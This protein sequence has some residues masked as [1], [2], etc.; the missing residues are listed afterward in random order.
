[1]AE[2]HTRG[3]Y[4][5]CPGPGGTCSETS[6]GVESCPDCFYCAC[7]RDAGYTGGGKDTACTAAKQLSECEVAPVRD[8]CKYDEDEA[9]DS[10]WPDAA[11]TPAVKYKK[12]G[13]PAGSFMKMDCKCKD[14]WT[15]IGAQAGCQ[16]PDNDASGPWCFVEGDCPGARDPNGSPWMYCVSTDIVAA[17]PGKTSKR[18][19]YP[20]ASNAPEGLQRAGRCACVH[21]AAEGAPLR[22]LH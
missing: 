22:P 9:C 16:N 14:S 12:L 10:D 18:S 20:T 1:M 13:T 6:D 21:A 5:W 3:P 19:Y 11:Q 7:D 17:K 4:A 2:P 15:Y 8:P